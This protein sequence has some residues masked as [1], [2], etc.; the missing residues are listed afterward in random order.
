MSIK[1]VKVFSTP[2]NY[3][4]E[5]IRGQLE[6]QSI[7]TFVLNKQDSMHSPIFGEIE[8]YVSSEDVLK[9]KHL[10]SKSEF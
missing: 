3:L 9:A 7:K 2:T 6:D 8:L 10:I 4:V 5:L 1:W